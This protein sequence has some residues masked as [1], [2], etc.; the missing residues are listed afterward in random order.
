MKSEN[1]KR[2]NNMGK[3]LMKRISTLLFLAILI[4]TVVGVSPCNAA[5]VGGKFGDA[6]EFDGINDYVLVSD[7]FSLR[8]PSTE[9]TIEAWVYLPSNSS[10]TK[11]VVRKWL[12]AT[13]GWMSYVLGTLDGKIYGG[14]ADQALVSFPSWKTAQNITELGFNGT[15]THVAFAWKKMNIT[16]DD[17]KIFVNG[18]SVNT[19]FLPQGYSSDFTIGYSAYPLYFARKA[20]ATWE[21]NYFKGTVDEVRIS[22]V[23]RTSFNLTSAPTVDAYTV[24]LWHFDEGAGVTAYDGSANANHG[25][26]SG[27]AWTGVIPE[28]PPAVMLIAL[29][30]L[31]LALSLAFRRKVRP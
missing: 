11:F 12:D 18:V 6:L 23:S 29:V 20:D 19:T 5:T 31:T 3:G 26:V 28:F 25:T 9:V 21:S 13:G 4:S 27:A 8:T 15:W 30:T 7:S 14:L 22:N 10:G 2:G 24:A 17:G 1:G 16:S